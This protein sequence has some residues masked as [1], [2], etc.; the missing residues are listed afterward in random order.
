M[1]SGADVAIAIGTIATAALAAVGLGVSVYIN[2]RDRDQA[3]EVASADRTAASDRAASDRAASQEDIRRR[4]IVDL[5]L[6]LG[7]Q[8]GRQAAYSGGPQ[9]AEAARQIQLLLLALPPECA[10]AT[11]MKFGG[12]RQ[13]RIPGAVGEKMQHLDLGSVAAPDPN[14]MCT[15]IAY[16]IDRYMTSG[17]ALQDVWG[18]LDEQREWQRVWRPRS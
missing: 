14:Q 8:I 15:E 16:D 13:M 2:K 4:H 18:D 3:L 1:S 7:R 9:S 12:I 10:Y 17:Q 6:E 11:R 5:L